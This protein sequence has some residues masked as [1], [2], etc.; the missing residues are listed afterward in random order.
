MPKAAIKNCGKDIK[1]L[2]DIS[3]FIYIKAGRASVMNLVSFDV[4]KGSD[5]EEID[6]ARETLTR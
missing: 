4:A 6:K 3:T 2:N 5:R 1:L